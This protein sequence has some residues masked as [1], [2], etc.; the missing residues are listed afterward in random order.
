V[1]DAVANHS[2][3]AGRHRHRREHG[4]GLKPGTRRLVH[5]I[6]QRELV[7]QEDRIEQACFCPLR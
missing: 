1:V 2:D 4:D 7:G 5:I 3:P 6:A